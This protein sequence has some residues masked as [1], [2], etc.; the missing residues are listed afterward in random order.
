[1]IDFRTYYRYIIDSESFSI[2]FLTQAIHDIFKDISID[3]NNQKNQKINNLE[4]LK[5]YL[6]EMR[7]TFISNT[8]K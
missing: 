1:M 8:K 3:E 7:K 2:D 5:P 6:K 4:D